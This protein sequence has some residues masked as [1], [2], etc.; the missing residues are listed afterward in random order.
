MEYVGRW[1]WSEVSDAIEIS[2]EMLD[3]VDHDVA[4]IID[5]SQGQG[6]P[7]LSLTNTRNALRKRHPRAKPIIMISTSDTYNLLWK[8]FTQVYGW[9]TQQHEY[10]VVKTLDE[11]REVFAS[12][13]ERKS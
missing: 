13:S 10:F 6:I 7:A 11:A 5:L 9:L 1:T 12:Y 3:T 8:H 2:S 4:Y